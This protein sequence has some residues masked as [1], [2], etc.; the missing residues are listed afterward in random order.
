MNPLGN[1]AAYFQEQA[2]S[3]ARTHPALQLIYPFQN[4]LVPQGD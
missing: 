2:F 4:S 1:A 3:Q